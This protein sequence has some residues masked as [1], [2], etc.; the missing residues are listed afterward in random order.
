MFLLP[1]NVH[2]IGPLEHAVA[3]LFAI[4]S[5]FTVLFSI[6]PHVVGAEA[7]HFVILPF[8][9][10]LVSLGVLV[11]A[12]AMW[13]TILKFSN[14]HISVDPLVSA[15]AM[16]FTILTFSTVLLSVGVLEGAVAIGKEGF[17]LCTSIA[18]PSKIRLAIIAILQLIAPLK[19]SKIIAQHCY[20]RHGK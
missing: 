9:T 19:N 16:Q 14:V 5:L 18:Y 11:S 4:L 12:M 15:V 8:S 3:I 6:G 2:T 10:V 20:K 17:F 1:S 13:F 7:L